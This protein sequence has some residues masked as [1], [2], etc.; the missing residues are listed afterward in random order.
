MRNYYK[1]YYWRGATPPISVVKNITIGDLRKCYRRIYVHKSND[2]PSIS[3]Q[4]YL[5]TIFRLFNSDKP[6]VNIR[7]MSAGDIIEI[8]KQFY[9][10]DSTGF[11]LL[12]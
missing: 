8:N 10:V 9:L 4:E 12:V 7:S 1:I 11:K 3:S 5:E 2:V 6:P